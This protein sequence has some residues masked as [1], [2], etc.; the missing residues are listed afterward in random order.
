MGWMGGWR[1][2]QM[3][4]DRL[5]YEEGGCHMGKVDRTACHIRKVVA[6]WGRWISPESPRAVSFEVISKYR[7][8]IGSSFELPALVTRG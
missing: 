1:N 3:R 8:S 5:P 7:I 2:A 6:I 4:S